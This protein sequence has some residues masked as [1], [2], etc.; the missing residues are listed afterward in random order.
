M[1]DGCLK[2]VESYFMD[3]KIERKVE[4]PINHPLNLDQLDQ[5]GFGFV[6]YCKAFQLGEGEA[7]M[8]LAFAFSDYLIKNYGFK[9]FKDNKPEYPLR[10]MTLK[11]DKE[12]IVLSLYPFEYSSK[13]L[14]G[15]ETFSELEEKIKSQ[16]R[17][18]P[19]LNQ[20]A[21]KFIN[22]DTTE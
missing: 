12:G 22:P 15:N 19:D 20:V 2:M 4:S 18:M 6:L 3:N 9:L 14:N 21:K 13:V 17:Q 16:I 7:M 1:L 11:Y 5:D 8:F 10:G